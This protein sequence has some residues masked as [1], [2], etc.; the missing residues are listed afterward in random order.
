MGLHRL[1]LYP[2]RGSPAFIRLAFE[3]V[4]T[5]S[6]PHEPTVYILVLALSPLYLA[7]FVF[8]KR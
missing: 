5:I 8:F 1:K 2:L 7:L 4:S 6:L 3:N